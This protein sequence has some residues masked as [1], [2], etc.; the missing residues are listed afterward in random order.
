M[1]KTLICQPM[2]NGV[3]EKFL[4]AGTERLGTH[5]EKN[6]YAENML[7]KATGSDFLLF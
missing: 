4:N 3:C 5:R 1:Q 7:S 2:F 6:S